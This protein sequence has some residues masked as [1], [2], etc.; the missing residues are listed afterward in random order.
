M[1]CCIV[2][3]CLTFRAH[4][5]SHLHTTLM[6]A[7]QGDH[8]PDSKSKGVPPWQ[9]RIRLPSGTFPFSRKLSLSHSDTTLVLLLDL[10][11]SHQSMEKVDSF[12]CCFLDLSS[13]CDYGVYWRILYSWGTWLGSSSLSDDTEEHVHSVRCYF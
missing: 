8:A 12:H 9:A 7:Y 6:D 5:L 2:W 13:R 3:P 11:G 4:S 1:S 10:P